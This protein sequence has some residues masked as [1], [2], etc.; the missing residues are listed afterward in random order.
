MCIL[1]GGDNYFAVVVFVGLHELEDLWFGHRQRHMPAGLGH[2]EFARKQHHEST[3]MAN[4]VGDT[5]GIITGTQVEIGARR[6]GDRRSR[7]LRNHQAAEG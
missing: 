3:R 5:T 6:S 2:V 7:I 1:V 4:A